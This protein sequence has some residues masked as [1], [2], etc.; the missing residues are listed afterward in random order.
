MIEGF[1]GLIGAGKTMLA[2]RHAGELARRRG[3][4]LASNIKVE[5]PGVECIQLAVGEDGLDLAQLRSLVNDREGDGRGLVVLVD[6]VGIIMPARFWQSFPVDLMFMLSQSRK[7]GVDLIYTAQDIEQVDSFLRRLT[8]WVYKVRAV[9]EAST[10][11]RERGKRPWL[12]LVS[13]WRPTTIDKPEKRV[14]RD[15]VRYRRSWE[16]WYDTDELVAPPERLTGARGRRRSAKER[17]LVDGDAGQLAVR[18]PEGEGLRAIAA[19][20]LG[21]DHQLDAGSVALAEPSDVAD[22]DATAAT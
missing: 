4:R 21:P 5:V 10:E 3:A 18:P 20:S 16:G 6:E 11:R 1:V 15:R 17:Q 9:P 19:G 2:V 12:F 13:K 7:L 8:Q 14:S 22:P